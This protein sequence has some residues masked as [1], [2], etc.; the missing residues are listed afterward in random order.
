MKCIVFVEQAPENRIIRLSEAEAFSLLYLNNYV[1]P[2]SNELEEQYI[3]VINYVSCAVP[4]Y[5]LYCDVS[6][7]AVKALYEELY[8]EEYHLWRNKDEI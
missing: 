2:F 1:Y 4:V 6:E 7:Q 5:R 3:N 8:G